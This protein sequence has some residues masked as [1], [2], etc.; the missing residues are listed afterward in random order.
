MHKDIEHTKMR[1]AYEQLLLKV[2]DLMEDHL[3]ERGM[4]YSL[5]AMR[6]LA[7]EMA[8]RHLLTIPAVVKTETQQAEATQEFLDD[9]R[10]RLDELMSEAISHGFIK[11]TH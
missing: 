4:R 9:I 2:R 8:A 6:E 10:E 1:N 5:Y 11:R 7:V 3:Q